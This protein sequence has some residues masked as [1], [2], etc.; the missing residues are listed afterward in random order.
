MARYVR[1]RAQ[2]PR[3]YPSLERGASFKVLDTLEDWG[4][5]I[6][7]PG[8]PFL[9]PNRRFVFTHHFEGVEGP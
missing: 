3:Q 7:A 6:E 4:M 1:L 5:W 2:F 9:N 8:D